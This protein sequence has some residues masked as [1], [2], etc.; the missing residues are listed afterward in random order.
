M[1][2]GRRLGGRLFYTFSPAYRPSAGG[3][4]FFSHRETGGAFPP[5]PFPSLATQHSLLAPVSQCCL[6]WRAVA[7]L[8]FPNS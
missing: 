1:N 7:A 5:R 8:V 4:S 6:V 3:A 2:E